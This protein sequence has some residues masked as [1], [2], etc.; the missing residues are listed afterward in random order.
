[1]NIVQLKTNR[2]LVLSIA[3]IVVAVPLLWYSYGDRI[4]LVYQVV[5]FGSNGETSDTRFASS[6]TPSS[7][8]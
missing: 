8:F 7:I 3:C 6:S 5:Y 2:V 4:A 1:M